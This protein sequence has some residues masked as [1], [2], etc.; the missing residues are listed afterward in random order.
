[1]MNI[2][3]ISLFLTSL[4]LNPLTVLVFFV[5]LALFIFM[6]INNYLLVRRIRNRK[7]ETY[8]SGR[9][10]E[11]AL[12]IS[13]NNV[14]RFDIRDQHLYTLYGDLYPKEGFAVEE[15][16]S[17]IH[18]DDLEATLSQFRAILKGTVQQAD[19]TYRWNAAPKGDEPRWLYLHDVT[20]AEYLP[21]MNRPISIISTL[22]DDTELQQAMAS[23]SELMDKYR[24]IFEN[25]II[26]LSFYSAD[27]WLLDTNQMMRDICHFDNTEYDAHFSETNLFD[28]PPFRECCDRDN[29]QE[30]WICT[31]SIIPERDI[32]DYLEIRLHPI[33]DNEGKLIYIAIATRNVTE[34]RELY[35]QAKQNDLDI[36]KANELIMNYEVEL[37]YMMEAC[38][39]QPWRINFEKRTIEYYKGLN[40]I[41]FSCSLEEMQK[42]FVDQDD[43]MVKIVTTPEEYFSGPV[44]WTG[45]VHP[46]F[47]HRGG[48]VWVQINSIPEYDEEGHQ[49]GCFGLWRDVTSL[50]SKQEALKHETERANDSARLKSVFLANMTHEIRTPLNAIVGFT[51]LLAAIDDAE[52]KREMVRVIHNNCDM[53]IR[54][55]NDILLLSNADANAIDIKPADVDA[56]KQFDDICHTLA[57]R[58][59]EPGVEFITDNPYS[60][61]R[62]RLDSAR[63]DQV[64]T[65]FV[66]NAI[67]YTHQGHIKVGY[68]MQKRDE[69]GKVTDDGTG[70]QGFYLYCE[71]TGTGIPKN[72]LKRIFERFVKLNDYIQGTGL[73]LSI[74]QVIIEKCGGKIGVDSEEGK[75]STFWFWIPAEI[76][77]LKPR[78]T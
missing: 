2:A 75:G 67:K 15:W 70:Q 24:I 65:N 58:V 76:K 30:L 43:P 14:I 46:V 39:M 48:D 23:E 21:G 68:C 71:D 6:S 13:Q 69:E 45:R 77:E 28:D 5:V 32:H 51:D 16:K 27:G 42:Q 20:I 78:L 19:F 10:M 64:V 33:R 40:T 55:I 26:G 60:V 17:R 34:E 9:L 49:T 47:T 56:S 74:C 66:T 62:T 38:K 59:Q 53:L 8:E 54:L 57:Q 35:L 4:K 52:S 36:Q 44:N 41:S 25:S 22:S 63:I 29:L 12:E 50:M 11:E 18:P 72:Q 31:Q 1:M 73:G 3:Y 61:C 7:K 37:N